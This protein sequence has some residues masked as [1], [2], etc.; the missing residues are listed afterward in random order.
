MWF[1]IAKVAPRPTVSPWFFNIIVALVITF[2]Q[3]VIYFKNVLK[4]VDISVGDNLLFFISMPL[5]LLFALNVVF[6]V[7]LLPY[8]RKPI[9]ILFFICDALAQYFMQ[10]YGI[11]IDRGMIQN[12]LDTTLVESVTLLTPRLA[13]FFLVF[14]ILPSL[15]VLWIK[16]KP[17]APTWQ[18]IGL[19]ILNV[20]LSLCIIALVAT[21]FYKDYAS[22]MRNNQQLVKNLVPSDMVLGSYSYYKHDYVQKMPFAE[23]GLDARKVPPA[24]DNHKKNL[25]ILVVGE[26][27]RAQDFSLGGY[28]K[29]TNPKLAADNVIYFPHTSSCGTATAVSV[30]CMFSGMTR[31]R[32]D[33]A[34][35]DSQSNALDIIQR[36]RVDVLWREND[37][38][39]KGVCLRVPTEQLGTWHLP[40]LCA[41]GVCLDE[42]MLRNLDG[43]IGAHDND[44]VIVLHTV[45]SHGPAYYQRYPKTAA[46]FT[47][48]CDTN[49]IQTCSNQALVN[50]Y[51]NTIVYI[52]D[53][54]DKTIKLLQAHNDKFNTALVYLSDHGESLGENGVYLHGMP[55][56]VAPAQ[57]THIPM[58]IW[59]SPGYL[60]SHAVR[61]DCLRDR[62]KRQAYSQD[63]LF[64]TLLGLVDVKTQLYQP[65]LDVL[66]PCRDAQQ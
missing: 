65:D 9:V 38:G 56:A 59:L 22:L 25:I 2:F 63:N 6:S 12:T 41:E 5:T 48:A 54:L 42:A 7:I 30:P 44:Q 46:A 39:C 45:G 57:Q 15:L 34:K 20:L 61:E 13:L 27:S 8:I 1:N 66:Q 55:Y 14:A 40:E 31:R 24:H 33:G 52:D 19:H 4:L 60:Q 3:N 35:A 32:Y 10:T 17:T 58:L 62:A 36:A 53:M 23:R 64:S 18:N 29:L 51:D 28:G 26:T 11:I 47:P 43:Y 21:F 16:V 37:G 50:T 49:E